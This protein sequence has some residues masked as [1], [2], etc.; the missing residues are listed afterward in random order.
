MWSLPVVR[1]AKFNHLSMLFDV[2]KPLWSFRNSIVNS[3][4]APFLC[5]SGPS[6]PISDVKF[7]VTFLEL[8]IA[9]EAR[10]NAALRAV[11]DANAFV[12]AARSQP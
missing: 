7:I 6:S 1:K 9:L 8:S 5:F 4:S 10:A 3:K 2:P 11:Q 12:V